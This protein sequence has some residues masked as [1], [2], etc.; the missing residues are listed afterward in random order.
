MPTR[1]IAISK[2]GRC[3][4]RGAALLIMLVILVVG[5]ATVLINSLTSSTVNTARQ[6][7][8]AAALA[9]AKEALIGYAAKD[10]TRPG[11]LPCPDVNDDG[12][13][14]MGTDY[15]GSNCV[16]PIGRLP[17]KTLGLPELHDGAGEH[18]WYTISKTFWANGSALINSDTQG[19]LIVSG[20]TTASNVIAIVFAAGPPANNQSRSHTNQVACATSGTTVAESLCAANYLEGNNAA[21]STVAVPNINYLSANASSTFNDQMILITPGNLFP[22]VE[23]RVAKELKGVFASYISANP[24]EYPNPANITCSTSTNCNFDTTQCRGWIP[25]GANIPAN[26]TLPSWFIPNGWYRVIYYSAGSSRLNSSPSGCNLTV[27]G[28]PTQALFFMPGLPLGSITRPSNNL[29]DYLEDAENQN[30]DD[31]YVQPGTTA[32]SNDSL[33][34]LP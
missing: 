11:E 6:A 22:V 16:S 17:W 3:K 32:I 14:T 20:S 34:T 5:I 25:I 26:W 4:Q 23:K 12:Q 15:I 21:L 8:T 18:L 10:T 30:M 7:T 1:R 9:Q 33:Y 31:T 24:G 19:S 28:A 29:S 13:L 2:H 27:S